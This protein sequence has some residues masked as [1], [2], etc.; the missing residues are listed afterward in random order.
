MGLHE[1]H[2]LG[3][4]TGG[5]NGYN[6]NGWSDPSYGWNGY[7]DHGIDAGYNGGGWSKPTYGYPDH[8]INAGYNENDCWSEPS[9]GWNGYPDHG[10]EVDDRIS[11]LGAR[12]NMDYRPQTHRVYEVSHVADGGWG[13]NYSSPSHDRFKRGNQPHVLTHWHAVAPEAYHEY[14]PRQDNLKAHPNSKHNGGSHTVYKL[15]IRPNNNSKPHDHGS[16][17]G[18]SNNNDSGGHKHGSKAS[19][20]PKVHERSNGRTNH[21]RVKPSVHIATH[22]GKHGNSSNKDD[23]GF[24]TESDDESVFTPRS[25][26]HSSKVSNKAHEKPNGNSYNKHDDEFNSDDDDE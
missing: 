8:G 3:S 11:Y 15:N 6:C 26:K 13:D 14:S 16:K 5:Y 24:N 21:I 23:D 18:N 1:G 17:H 25:H 20:H 9:Y 7:P 2:G 12:N 22:Y 19:N 4:R 10:I